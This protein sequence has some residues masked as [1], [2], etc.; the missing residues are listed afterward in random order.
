[1]ALM[2][3][4]RIKIAVDNKERRGKETYVIE[5]SNKSGK[6]RPVVKTSIYTNRKDFLSDLMRGDYTA[7]CTQ[8]WYTVSFNLVFR[9]VWLAISWQAL[10]VG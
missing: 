5:K 6:S 1:M 7:L 4:S 9:I 2:D 10:F 8:K 3:D